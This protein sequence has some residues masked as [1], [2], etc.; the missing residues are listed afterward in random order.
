[1]KI[2]A[3]LDISDEAKTGLERFLVGSVASKVVGH[4]PCPVMVVR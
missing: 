3:A 1:M 4:A 2:L